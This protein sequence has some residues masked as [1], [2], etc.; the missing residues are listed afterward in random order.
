[1]SNP[2]VLIVG[3]GPTGLAC[4]RTLRD[5]GRDVTVIESSSRVGG[6]LGSTVVEGIVCD[7]GFQV[8]MS[9]YTTLEEL[10]PRN[11]APRHAFTSGA[12]VVTEDRRIRMV[13]P[14]REPLAG[15]K[16]WW[17]G[18]ARFR[19][20]RAALRCRRAAAA[21]TRRPTRMVRR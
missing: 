16:A 9:N 14:G 15:L 13:D 12:I 8:S 10:A 7:L 1:M 5:A 20:L 21:R 18:L 4:A 3:A 6:R 2:P 19:D 17:S 11:A